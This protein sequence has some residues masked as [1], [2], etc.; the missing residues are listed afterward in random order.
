MTKNT[1]DT[2]IAFVRTAAALVAVVAAAF[3]V[4][5]DAE[6]LNNIAM[7]AVAGGIVAWGCWKDNN[8]TSAASEAHE[9]VELFKKTEPRC[10]MV[11]DDDGEEA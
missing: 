9:F 1:A 8:F 7:L 3:G 5:M 2:I 11:G 4:D 6:L 10:D